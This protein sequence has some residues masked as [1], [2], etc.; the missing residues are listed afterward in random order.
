M[1][2]RGHMVGFNPAA[3]RIVLLSRHVDD[4]F[5]RHALSSGAK[6]YI[7]KNGDRT[8]LE[9]TLLAVARGETWLSPAV[10]TRMVATF[11]QAAPAWGDG[12]FEVLT[13][14]QREVLQL[15]AE[16]LSNKEIAKRVDVSVKTVESHRNELMERLGIRGVAGLVRYAIRVG[17]VPG[18]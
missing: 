3:E 10:S 9:L 11:A 17:L 13:P 7:L 14:R 8:E 12:P 4:E 6:E 1:D 2:Q 16:A 15:I 18:S 5:V